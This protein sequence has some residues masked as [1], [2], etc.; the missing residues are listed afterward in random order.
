MPLK[1]LREPLG[2]TRSFPDGWGAYERQVEAEQPTVGKANPQKIESKH[3]NWRT[4]SKR[5]VRRTIGCSKTEHRH[6]LVSGLF[7]NRYEFGR[8][9]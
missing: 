6:D 4:R 5:L 2:I 3:S 9:I 8:S 1:A 7:I